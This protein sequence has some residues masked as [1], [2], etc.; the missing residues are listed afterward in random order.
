M[1][2]SKILVI[3]CSSYI[4]MG[5]TVSILHTLSVGQCPPVRRTR[6]A[7]RVHK[8]GAT[9]LHTKWRPTWPGLGPTTRPEP[10]PPGPPTTRTSRGLALRQCLHRRRCFPSRRP[11]YYTI[12]ISYRKSGRR[13][14]VKESFRVACRTSLHG[15]FFSEWV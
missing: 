1:G 6:V 15:S 10:G 8:T 4:G 11:L 7:R 12:V 9:S 3:N 13:K 14:N 5:S 2:D